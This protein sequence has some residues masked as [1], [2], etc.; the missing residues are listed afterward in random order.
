MEMVSSGSRGKTAS[1][2]SLLLKSNFKVMKRNYAVDKDGDKFL[3][4]IGSFSFGMD[5][6]NL[7]KFVAMCSVILAT[8][9][10]EEDEDGEL[11]YITIGR[12]LSGGA[13]AN[14][15]HRR[16]DGTKKI[17][18][19]CRKLIKKINGGCTLDEALAVAGTPPAIVM[20]EV[21]SEDP[22]GTD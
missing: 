16:A 14:L 19:W 21:D 3:D 15:K 17:V 4:T 5:R 6:G 9:E 7:G 13:L 2:A 8:E 18:D 12:D 22:N 20:S 1:A 11:V 10:C